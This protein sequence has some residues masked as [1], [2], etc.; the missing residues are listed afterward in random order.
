MPTPARASLARCAL[1]G[2]RTTRRDASRLLARP[3]ARADANAARAGARSSATRKT[4]SR[5]D[6]DDVDVDASWRPMEAETADETVGT[7]RGAL[8][9]VT[10]ASGRGWGRQREGVEIVEGPRGEVTT[11]RRAEDAN[12]LEARTRS[13][14]G[15]GERDGDGTRVV[16]E[17]EVVAVDDEGRARG[18]TGCRRRTGRW[19][20]RCETTTTRAGRA[21]RRGTRMMRCGR[22]M[23]R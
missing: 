22:E 13:A 1:A 9:G 20:A 2:D 4:R 19:S 10:S 8:A 14:V 23:R 6:D 16:V 21:R 12:A 3:P 18:V 11:R 5:D 17:E 7:T 15:S